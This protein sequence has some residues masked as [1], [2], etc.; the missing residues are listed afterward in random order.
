MARAKRKAAAVGQPAPKTATRSRG[1]V[2]REKAAQAT[3]PAVIEAGKAK[4]TDAGSPLVI[5]V[6]KSQA[7]HI[8]TLTAPKPS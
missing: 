6:T 8:R 7:E 3:K 1:N 4:L 5:R 2:T